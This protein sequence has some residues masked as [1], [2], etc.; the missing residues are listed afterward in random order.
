M[1]SIS[2][3]DR[4]EAALDPQKE[5]R[6][7]LRSIKYTRGF[8]LFFVQCAPAEGKRLVERVREDLT[9]KQIEILSLER[10]INNLFNL[11]AAL[12][13]HDQMDVL[14]IEGLEHS[15][16]EYEK[17]QLWND[18]G[19]YTYIETSVPHLLQHLNLGRERFQQNFPFCWVFLL[20]QF[21][22]KYFIRRAPD[23]FDWR[24]GVY[25]F[26]M[27]QKL[28]QSE[29]EH[30][31]FERLDQEDTE[32]L[33]ID[34]C[35]KRILKIQALLD[36]L[37]QSQDTR[38]DLLFEQARLFEIIGE[39]ES[40]I[41]SYDQALKYKPDKH[42]AWYNR[43]IILLNL[44]H[45]EEAISSFDQA[46]KSK[47]SYVNAWY[48]RGVVLA[49]LGRVEEAISNLDQALKFEPDDYQIWYGRGATLSRL[50]RDSEAIISYDQALKI[51]PDFSDALYGKACLYALQSSAE[52]ATACLSRAIELEPAVYLDLAKTNSDFDLIRDDPRF[53]ALVYAK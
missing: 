48:N 15:L 1:T 28:W 9:Q 50:N 34:D 43:G 32:H 46:L 29:S 5:Y 21:A 19:T 18:P 30:A 42:Q 16:Y 3:N 47:P 22:L 38:V 51:K 10:P 27:E 25:E 31:S 20:P 36:E 53:Q 45:S 35:R 4:Q 37:H 41:A 33:S 14:F 23:F 6:A 24:S 26:A 40:A 12:P 49:N 2:A 8:G 52:A 7:L 17:D 11:V 13:N 44:G 39:L